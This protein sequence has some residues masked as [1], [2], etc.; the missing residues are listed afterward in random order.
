MCLLYLSFDWL[1]GW[2]KKLA[3]AIV[4]KHHLEI[5]P[6]PYRKRFSKNF[7]QKHIT[8]VLNAERKCINNM[9]LSNS[10]IIFTITRQGN[11]LAA[12]QAMAVNVPRRKKFFYP[13]MVVGDFVSSDLF[14]ILHNT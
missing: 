13:W 1:P 14:C 7:L 10:K 8:D 4:V 5:I 9:T 3:D 6:G 11:E 12:A 2:N